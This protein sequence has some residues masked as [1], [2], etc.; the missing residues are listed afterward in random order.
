[1]ISTKW[2]FVTWTGAAAVWWFN[3]TMFEDV[4]SLVVA[5]VFTVGAAK[6]FMDWI[7]E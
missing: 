5:I 4:L 2:A 3:V 1:M 7:E 6:Y